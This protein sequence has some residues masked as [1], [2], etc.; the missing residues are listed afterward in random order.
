MKTLTQAA[1][2][3]A[4][5][6]VPGL[7]AAGSPCSGYEV[8]NAN[9]DHVALSDNPA[10]SSHLSVGTCLG[11]YDKGTCSFRDRDGDEYTYAY[12]K[13]A[14]ASEGNWKN[15]RGTG[16]YAKA[17]SSGVYRNVGWVETLQ[18]NAWS[19]DCD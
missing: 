11:D 6:S 15:V 13:P 18:I 19:G 2:L 3:S 4:A 16:K 8:I 12:E 17:R 9:G 1:W 7:A 10:L 14:G 5:L